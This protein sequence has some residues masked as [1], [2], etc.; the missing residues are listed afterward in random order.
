MDDE[1]FD[2]VGVPDTELFETGTML[3]FARRWPD[4]IPGT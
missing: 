4:S 3:D 2:R 1:V